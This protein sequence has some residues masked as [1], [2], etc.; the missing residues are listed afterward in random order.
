LWIGRLSTGGGVSKGGKEEKT[1]NPLVGLTNLQ[2]F[3]GKISDEQETLAGE[4]SALPETARKEGVK[5][6]RNSQL[7]QETLRHFGG[8]LCMILARGGKWSIGTTGG[9]GLDRSPGGEAAGNSALLEGHGTEKGEHSIK[10][11][12][13]SPWEW[14]MGSVND[15]EECKICHHM[16]EKADTV[17]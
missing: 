1:S 6:N 10:G 9:G 11:A 3:S 2:G 4:I 13:P 12:H 17:Q 16:G 15:S 8:G 14:K 5:R 7:H